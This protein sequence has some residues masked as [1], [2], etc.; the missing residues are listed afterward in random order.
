MTGNIAAEV[1]LSILIYE[2]TGSALLSA[3]VFVATFLPYAVGGTLFSSL[4]DRFP[5][6]RVL[7]G[8]DLA[9]GALIAVMLVRGAPVWALLTLLVGIGLIAPVFQGARAA[10]LS[11]LLPGELFALGR[12][13][14][15]LVS[16]SA[17]LLGFTVGGLLVAA[18]GPHWL[19]AAD[20]IS[21]GL[22]AVMIGFATPYVPANASGGRATIGALAR[23]SAAGLQ[24][25]FTDPRLRWLV[26]LSWLAALFASSIDGIAVAYS[27]QVGVEAAAAAALFAAAAVGTVLG[28]LLVSR[29]TP[30]TRRRLLMPLA[31][32]TQLPNL[33]FVAVPPIWLGSVL[34]GVSGL[35]FAYNQAV[36]PLILAATD[37]SLRGRL[38]TV[39]SSGLMAVQGIGIAIAGAVST[40]L[41]PSVVITGAAALGIVTIVTVGT[42]ALRAEG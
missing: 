10:S 38:F 39:Q 30:T 34:I 25:V 13:L 16:Q 18:I 27:A 1:A 41:A 2:R 21:F 22:S 7:V 5:A 19:L 40:V 31:L 20:A 15:R 37:D 35:G 36:D 12:S 29:L 9:S 24:Y 11:R 28:E 3:L 4:A 26:P 42:R 14:L 8:C 32:L 6:R 17:V 33:G 23:A